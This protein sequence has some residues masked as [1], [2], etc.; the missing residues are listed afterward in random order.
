MRILRSPEQGTCSVMQEV[1]TRTCRKLDLDLYHYYHKVKK[2]AA[3]LALG[4]KSDEFDY[5]RIKQ[6]TDCTT[7]SAKKLWYATDIILAI[8]KEYTMPVRRRQAE[9]ESIGLD[10]PLATG[11]GSE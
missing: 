5:Y 9:P 10:F 11:Q 1:A 3:R 4:D 7:A 8:M 2:I 6:V